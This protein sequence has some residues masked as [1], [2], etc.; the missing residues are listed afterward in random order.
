M[1][2]T[3]C[4]P[5]M[6]V[7]TPCGTFSDGACEPCRECTPNVSFALG[8]CD[9]VPDQYGDTTC[10][11]CANCTAGVQYEANGCG[12]GGHGRE[13]ETCRVCN[14]VRGAR[15]PLLCILVV[16]ANARM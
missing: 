10:I 8:D 9:S 2:C 1:N 4:G 3:V 15:V 11:L 12:E 7:A 13:C 5:G 6:R 14:E 16:N